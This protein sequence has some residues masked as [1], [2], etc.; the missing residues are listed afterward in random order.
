LNLYL[1]ITLLTVSVF[2]R[3]IVLRF[4][5]LTMLI[6]MELAWAE[7]IARLVR[8]EQLLVSIRKSV[9][10]ITRYF[11]MVCPSGSARAALILTC[12]WW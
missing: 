10:T 6:L 2:V 5:D 1:A 3:T 8:K 12:L 9:A 4:T 11:R 7:L